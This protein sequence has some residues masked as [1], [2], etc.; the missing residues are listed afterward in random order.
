[1]LPLAGAGQSF[2]GGMDTEV[3]SVMNQNQAALHRCDA[4]RDPVRPCSMMPAIA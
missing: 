3:W 4:R 2:G 1:V